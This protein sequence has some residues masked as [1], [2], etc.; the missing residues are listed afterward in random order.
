MYC[1]GVRHRNPWPTV[2]RHPFF[3]QAAATH[4]AAG[5][6]SG[7]GASGVFFLARF[8]GKGFLGTR[9]GFVDK[10]HLIGGYHGEGC[11]PD[12]KITQADCPCPAPVGLL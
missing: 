4:L 8:A 9:A 7:T 2:L 3:F 5:Q 10:V 6:A 11:G 1:Q 12:F